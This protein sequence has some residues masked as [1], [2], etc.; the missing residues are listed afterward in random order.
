[1]VEP[2]VIR[3]MLDE[4]RFDEAEKLANRADDSSLREA[5]SQRRRE[6]EERARDLS[7]RLIDLGDSRD[8][9]EILELARDRATRPLLHLLPA[10]SR[11]RPELYLREAE[12]WETRKRETNARR[13]AEARKALEGLD[14]ELAQG[15]MKRLD[16]RFLSEEE[17]EQRD[18][19]L[20]DISARS[21]EVE[22][23]SK[24]GRRLIDENAPRRE[25]GPRA[26]PW[27][28]RWFG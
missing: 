14:L 13:L 22:A 21:M 6:A 7:Q 2:S 12:R 25:H 4:L 5:V 3:E 16:G 18:R 27:W 19:L 10:T 15:L 20:L 28:R 11:K 9:H 23:L 17:V 8:Y 26:R 1:M 24:T